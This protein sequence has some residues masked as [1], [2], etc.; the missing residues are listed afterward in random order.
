MAIIIRLKQYFLLYSPKSDPSLERGRFPV[1]FN[2]MLSACL[3]LLSYLAL[4][5]NSPSKPR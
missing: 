3:A 1:Y 2:V 4:A 5:D